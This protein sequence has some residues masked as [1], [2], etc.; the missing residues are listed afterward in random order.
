MYKV[1]VDATGVD[2]LD[3]PQVGFNGKW[4]TVA[5]N[6]FSVA[7]NTYHGAKVF[8]FNKANVVAGIS[9]PYTSFLR[10]TSYTICPAITYD[11]AEQNMFMVESWDGTAAAGGQM[12]LWKIAGNVGTETMTSVGFPASA[13]FRWQARG[14]MPARDW[15][16]NR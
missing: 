3:Y 1:L 7:S 9:A 12:E 10:S 5:G 6:M 15:K 8:V 4:I 2:W 16:C 14:K 13:G 11:V